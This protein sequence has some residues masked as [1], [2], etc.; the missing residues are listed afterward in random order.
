VSAGTWSLVGLELPA[1]LIDD[2]T[3]AANLTNEGGAAG[4]TRLLRNVAG[5]W[6]LQECRRAWAADGDDWSFAELVAMA[7]QAPPLRALVDPDDPA[8]GTPGDMPE[9][10]REACL[11][12]GQEPPDTPGEVVRCVLESIALAHRRV[13]DLLADATGA[14]PPEV[15]VVGGGSRNRLLCQWTADAARLPVLAGPEEATVIGNLIVQAMA[16][17]ELASLEEGRELVRASFEPTSYEPRPGDEWDEAYARFR[18]L[19]AEEAVAP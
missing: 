8:L 9:R 4:T 10:I 13:L 19:R 14:A 3:F 7:E 15:H 11:R 18:Q 1:P 2:R 5:L 6:L 17:G 16:L 12:A